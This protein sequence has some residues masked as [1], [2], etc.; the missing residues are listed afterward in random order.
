MA[1][2]DKEEF[3]PLLPAGFHCLDPTGRQRLC[4]ERFP[5][6]VTRPRIMRSVEA[7]IALINQQAISGEIWIDGSFLTEKLNPDD[8]DIAFLIPGTVLRSL[9]AAQRSFFDSFCKTSYYE[10]FRIDN[11]GVAIDAGAPNGQW[12]YA[13]WLRQF[14][15][16][17]AEEMK[18]ILQIPVP[19][20]V[21]P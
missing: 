21:M 3:S 14:G 16:S 5:D 2:A 12:L 15:F 6:S 10:Q 13:Y 11:Y 7:V 19:F 8:A 4:V 1:G 17:R 18:G 20:V 9:N